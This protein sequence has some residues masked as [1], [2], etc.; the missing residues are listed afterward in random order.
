MV[1]HQMD[2]NSKAL[3]GSFTKEVPPLLTVSSGD[4]IRFAVPDAAWGVGESYAERKKPYARRDKL[5]R[6]HALIGPFFL[7]HAKRGMTLAIRFNRI[8]PGRY[9]FTSAGQYPNWQNQK[10]HLT[11]E[12]ELTLDWALDPEK[13]EGSCQI[14]GATYSVPLRPFMG[15]VGMPPE[16][17]GIHSTWPPR[18]C[19]GNIDCKEL[20]SGSTIFLPIPVDGAYLVIGDGHAAQGDGEVSCQAIECPMEEVEITVDLLQ[21]MHLTYPR[22]NTP[23]GWLTFGFHEDLNEATVQALDGML[24]LMGELYGLNRVEAMAVGSAAIDLRITQIVN[25]VKGVHACLPHGR[26]TKKT[27]AS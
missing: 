7:E 15:I 25:G 12:R 23:F 22:A 21:D 26:I 2:L 27:T 14:D 8:V 18:F 1:V 17:T 16:E 10:L 20:V 3:I 19:G 4:T 11:D 9:G 6:G 13:M 5:D 24:G